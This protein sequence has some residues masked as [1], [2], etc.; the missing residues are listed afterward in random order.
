MPKLYTAVVT[1]KGGRNGHVQSSDGALDLDL[2]KPVEMGGEGGSYANPE[3]LFAGAY[4]ACYLSA[5]QM[6]ADRDRVDVSDASVEVHVNFDN[7]FALSAE[8]Y[9]ELPN[10]EHERAEKL[11]RRA[12]DICPYS[13]ATRGNI[14]VKLVVEG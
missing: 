5:L 7:S 6:V 9:L 8:I 1:A 3:Q 13:R 12:H 14:E 2:K 4:G 10:I 11:A